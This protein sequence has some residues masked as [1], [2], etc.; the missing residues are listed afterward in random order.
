MS[1]K[2]PYDLAFLEQELALAELPS[3]R[4]LCPKPFDTLKLASQVGWASIA[5]RLS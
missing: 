3:M 1:H 2:L 5:H 4:A